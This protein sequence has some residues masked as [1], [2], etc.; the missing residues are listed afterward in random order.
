[1]TT[2]RYGRMGLLALALAVCALASIR[3][4]VRAQDLSAE[5][6]QAAAEA[7]YDRGSTAYRTGDYDSAAR[8][9]ETANELAPSANALIQA[10]RAHE[11]GGN[12]LRAATLGMELKT[13]YGEDRMARHADPFIDRASQSGVRV[14]IT[15]DGCRVSVNGEP[16]VR[17]A[18]F[19]RPDTEHL[20]VATFSTGTVEERVLGRPGERRELALQ[21]PEAPEPSLTDP[22][23]TPPEDA[24]GGVEVQLGAGTSPTV[25]EGGGIS[26]GF[27][28]TGVALT[29]ISGGILAW[30][31]MDTLE[32]SEDY[33]DMPTREKLENGR[34]LERRTNILIGTTSGL[35]A[36]SILLLLLTDFESDDA[37]ER[38]EA[39]FAPLPEGGLV[40]S[41]AGRLP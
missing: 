5:E 24:E 34:D 6:R 14:D 36:I 11:R 40:L 7:A 23:E 17:R 25:D 1:M 15:C 16:E 9:Y 33:R 19:L 30:S 21:A 18:L 3:A 39:A 4:G 8:W 20:I 28:W 13:R 27:F 37:D 38:I 2:D 29:V 35:A 32:A 26:P 10:M 12:I 22:Q 41:A 31:A